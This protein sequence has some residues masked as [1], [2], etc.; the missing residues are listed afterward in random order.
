MNKSWLRKTIGELCEKGGGKVQTG[1]FGSQLH[2]TDYSEEG[3]PVVMPTDIPTGQIN[4]TRIARVSE[5][6][7]HRLSRHKLRKGDIV[8]GRRGDIGRQAFVRKENVGWLCGTG[9]LRIRLGKSE[10]D[11]EYLHRYLT[12]P[13]IKGWIEGQAVGATMPNLNTAILNRVPVCYPG[14]GEQRKIAAILTAYDDLIETNKRRIALLERMA[15]EI[16]REWFVRMRF[17]GYQNTEFVKGMPEGWEITQFGQIANMIMGQSPKSEFYNDS[18]QGLPFHQGVGTYGDRFPRNITFC[19]ADGRKAKKGDI[20]F[21]VRAP[22]GRLNIANCELMIGRGIAAIRQREGKNSYLY[23]LMRT[24][25]ANEDI[26]GNGSIF[27]SVGKDELSR[28][29]V[30]RHPDHLTARFEKIALPIDQKIE[31]LIHSNSVLIKT[32]DLLLPRLIS[33]KISVVDLDI[34]FPP[35]MCEEDKDLGR[36]L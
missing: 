28:F 13:E 10:V 34:Q 32:R 16:Y 12:L 14:L 30:L 35:S 2:Q 31:A 26:I 18:G 33:G 3:T 20:L 8:Y 11:P 21:S 24:M 6:H 29:V 9:C 5:T 27:N 19:T 17:P 23:Y 4:A 36:V 22:V 15:E 7:V 25:F 1:P